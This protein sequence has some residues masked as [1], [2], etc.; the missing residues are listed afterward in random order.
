MVPRLGGD[1]TLSSDLAMT[2]LDDRECE[3]NELFIIDYNVYML[4]AECLN[5]VKKMCMIRLL[6]I[7]IKLSTDAKF[8]VKLKIVSR[9]NFVGNF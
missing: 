6:I 9:P 1:K 5:I 2:G 7:D 8:N 3:E 4:L